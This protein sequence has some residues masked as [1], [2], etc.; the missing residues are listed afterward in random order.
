[1]AKP[2]GDDHG[3]SAAAATPITMPASISGDIEASGDVDWLSFTAVAG[4]VYEFRTTAESLSDT[5]LGLYS[6]DGT[7]RLAFNDDYGDDTTSFIRWM[8]ADSGPLYVE[9]GGY[10]RQT[11]TYGLSVSIPYGDANMDSIFNSGDLLQVFQIGEYEDNTAGNSTWA[12]GD[13]NGDG[14]FDTS[15]LVAAFQGNVYS[16]EARRF[17][18]LHDAV[19]ATRTE[20][21]K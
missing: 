12:D 8:A 6:A 18:A 17:A 1:L 5:T 3:N 4:L 9:V 2:T 16:A 15:D 11:G 13:W 21:R 14:E 10:G 7:T 19:F 20:R